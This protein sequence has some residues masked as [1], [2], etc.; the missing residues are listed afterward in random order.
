[1]QAQLITVYFD[2]GSYGNGTEFQGYGSYQVDG[3][4]NLQHLA[5]RMDF[6]SPVTCNQAEYL[7]LIAALKW[8]RHHVEP[9]ET[10]LSVWSDSLLVVSQVQKRWKTRVAHL[11]ELRDEAKELLQPY[12]TWELKWYG[13][14][15][16]VRRFGH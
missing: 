14:E 6:G 15:N 8:L 10:H 2:G 7:S 1:M 16:S 3:G 12:L 4:P 5:L 9:K 13:R 11:K